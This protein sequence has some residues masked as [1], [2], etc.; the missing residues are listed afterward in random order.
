MK[1]VAQSSLTA[2]PATSQKRTKKISPDLAAPSLDQPD[3][4]S[5]FDSGTKNSKES[6]HWHT[7]ACLNSF[8]QRNGENLS[9]AQRK[10]FSS[11]LESFLEPG[12]SERIDFRRD[13]SFEGMKSVMAK[14][15]GLELEMFEEEADTRANNP[16]RQKKKA[17]KLLTCQKKIYEKTSTAKVPYLLFTSGFKEGVLGLTGKE[18]VEKASSFIKDGVNPIYNSEKFR[19]VV[20]VTGTKKGKPTPSTFYEKHGFPLSKEL[21]ILEPVVV[22][23]IDDENLEAKATSLTV[24]LIRNCDKKINMGAFTMQKMIKL[25]GE[26]T[27]T[28][29]R[30]RPQPSTD[31]LRMDGTQQGFLADDIE[32]KRLLKE[33]LKNHQHVYEVAKKG[34]NSCLSSSPIQRST[35]LKMQKSL[36]DAQLECSAATGDEPYP[37]IAFG[38]NIDIDDAAE[39][40]DALKLL[41]EFTLPNKRLMP[42]L[43]E[44]LAG[45]NQVQIYCKGPGSR[46]VAH[47][48]NQGIGSVNVNIGPDDCV[49]F[50]ISMKYAAELEKLLCHK[51]CAQYRSQIW[52]SEEELKKAGISYLKFLQKKGEMVFINTGTYHWVQSNGFA[53]NIAWNVLHDD[54]IPLASAALSNDDTASHRHHTV[55]PVEKLIWNIA[56]EKRNMGTNFSKV[57]K[58]M[59][60]SSLARF[61]IELDVVRNDGWEILNAADCPDE[62]QFTDYC[63]NGCHRVWLYNMFFVK[64]IEVTKE[65]SE[66]TE[67]KLGSLCYQCVGS[68]K[69]AR[70]YRV[71]TLE[72]LIKIYDNYH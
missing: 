65:E 60:T 66:E 56:K 70:C 67:M 31:N 41:P 54:W 62:L 14:L 2:T 33:V 26:K 7:L 58:Q 8:F 51:R 9:D 55:L 11:I 19:Y 39:Q 46:T 4:S 27:F 40:M 21:G 72:E 24:C 1:R 69:N 10:D 32:E 50:C 22:L 48:E 20:D 28:T 53:S 25:C 45:V 5:T 61:K 71:H 64:R 23:D 68:K 59:L 57:V 43:K 52:P 63:L 16:L 42:I 29:L 30:Q 17:R 6:L 47:Y 49:W 38:S 44:K 18:V 35:I 36:R 12:L 34:F 13:L 37:I 15:F 3:A